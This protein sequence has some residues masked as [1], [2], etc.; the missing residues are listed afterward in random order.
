MQGGNGGSYD[1]V[2]WGVAGATWAGR[3]YA[4][5]GVS[6]TG[7]QGIRCTNVGCNIY[8][9]GGGG[10]GYYGGGGGLYGC[11]GGGSSYASSGVT[12]LDNSH[13]EYLAPISGGTTST[14]YFLSETLLKIKTSSKN[15]L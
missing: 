7:G 15:E 5:S 6:M 13:G 3:V 2:S 9:G 8:G 14:N 10:G 4:P 1:Q 11:G 12:V